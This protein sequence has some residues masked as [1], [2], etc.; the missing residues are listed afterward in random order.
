MNIEELEAKVRAVQTENAQKVVQASQVARLEA[1]LRLES[2]ES[3]FRSKVALES[4]VYQTQRLQS[5]IDECASIISQ[6]PVQNTKTRAARVWSES[7]RYN[8]GTQVD[9]MYQL[10]SGILYSCAEHKPLLLEHTGLTLELV[11]ELV[12]AFG[13]PSYYSRNYH[14]IVESKPYNVDRIN[15]IL[16]V[17]QSTLGVVISTTAVTEDSLSI[18]FVRGEIRAQQDFDNAVEAISG[19]NFSI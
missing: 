11:E 17:M 4:S 10:A 18:D 5:L 15:T 6:V 19:S 8:F 12:T 16:E 2:S 14:S 3:L 1:T 13:S 9:L 7:H